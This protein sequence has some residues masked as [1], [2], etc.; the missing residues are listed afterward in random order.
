MVGEHLVPLRY[1]LAFLF[2][3]VMSNKGWA[4]VQEQLAIKGE[5]NN[6]E[7]EQLF[8]WIKENTSKGKIV[9]TEKC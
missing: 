8:T 3:A 2:I 7:Q 6:P 4:N 9:S 5:Y 1:I